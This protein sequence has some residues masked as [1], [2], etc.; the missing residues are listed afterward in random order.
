MQEAYD[1]VF[2]AVVLPV[3]D[4]LTATSILKKAKYR[5]PI[6]PMAYNIT[7]EDVCVYGNYGEYPGS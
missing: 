3:M 2:M 1:I 5:G 4:G 6:V 7:D